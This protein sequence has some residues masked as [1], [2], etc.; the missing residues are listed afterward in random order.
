MTSRSQ[1]ELSLKSYEC[2]MIL[3]HIQLFGYTLS[4][5]CLGFQNRGFVREK[6][7]AN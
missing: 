1:I 2:F 6:F 5:F 7:T 4:Q 3:Q